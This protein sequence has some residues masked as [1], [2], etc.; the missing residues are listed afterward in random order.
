MVGTTQRGDSLVA[1]DKEFLI[2]PDSVPCFCNFTIFY[3]KRWNNSE[4]R[5]LTNLLDFSWD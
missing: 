4:R 5:A 1:R 2:A 3:N